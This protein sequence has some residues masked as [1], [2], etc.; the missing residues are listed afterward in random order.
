MM[1]QWPSERGRIEPVTTVFAGL[2]LWPVREPYNSSVGQKAPALWVH[3]GT[4]VT[5]VQA[6]HDAG[7]LCFSAKELTS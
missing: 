6:T 2:F 4:V 3:P 7:V 1:L 5:D